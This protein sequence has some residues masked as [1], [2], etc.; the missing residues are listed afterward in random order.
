MSIPNRKTR[1]IV[2]CFQPSTQNFPMNTRISNCVFSRVSLPW[3]VPLLIKYMNG[4]RLQSLVGMSHS[5]TNPLA[6]EDE[7]EVTDDT[8]DEDVYGNEDFVMDDDNKKKKGKKKAAAKGNPS[9]ISQAMQTHVTMPMVTAMDAM[10]VWKN[11]S[12]GVKSVF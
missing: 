1:S 9:R 8:E 4:L 3:L 11:P 6:F 12:F 10:A 2:P 5:L 7:E